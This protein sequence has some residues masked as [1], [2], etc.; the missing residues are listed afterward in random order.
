VVEVRDVPQP[1][2]GA[3]DVLIRVHAAAIN[4]LDWKIRSG[5]VKIFTGRTFPKILGS[6]CAGEVVA[7]GGRVQRFARGDQ[8]IGLPGM[9]RLGTFAEYVCSPQQTTFPKPVNITFSHAATIP[10]AGCTALQALRDLGRLATGQ[11]VLINGASGGVGTF[12]VQIAR[13]FA[14]KVTAVCSG[15]NSALVRDLG[16]DRVIDYTGEDFT[17]G[18]ERYD[19]IFDA[20]AKAS[21]TACRKVLTPQGRYVT[22]LPTFAV[23]LNQFLSGCLTSQKARIVMARPNARDMEWLKGEIEAGRIRIVIDREYPLAQIRE[24]LAYS[25]AG[26]A[27]GKVVLQISCEGDQ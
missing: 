27:K 7:T 25:E 9:K 24:A 22:T 12:A 10:I 3:D 21:W 2:P 20:V 26:K 23:L 19:L 1:Q 5:M 16:A 17:K 15:A 11:H 13:I 18:N 14:A 8:V 6:E 4:P